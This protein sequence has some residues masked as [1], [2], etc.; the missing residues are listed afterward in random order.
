VC[1]F[2]G[3]GW[4]IAQLFTQRFMYIEPRGNSLIIRW[5]F[6][7][8]NYHI[9][10]KDHNNSICYPLAEA[11]LKRIQSDIRS[12][13]FD[14]TLAKYCTRKAKAAKLESITASELFAKYAD[15]RMEDYELSNSSKVR[16]EGISSKL[17]QLL[18]EKFP[19]SKV[20]ADVAANVIAAWS[21]QASSRTIRAYLFD[22]AAA[23]DWAKKEDLYIL[24]DINPWN[25]SLERL[26]RVKFPPAKKPKPFTIEELKTIAQGF[27]NHPK[28]SYY[29]DAA[30]FISQTA[31][32]FGEMAAL[33]WGNVGEN[34]DTVIFAAS[35]SRGHHRDTTKTGESRT[36]ALTRTVREMLRSRYLSANPNPVELVFPAP[37][38][39]YMNDNRFRGKIWKPVLESCGIDYQK[40]YNLRHTGVSHAAASGA[41]LSALAEQTGHSKRTLVS[42]YLHAIGQECLFV[43]I[44]EP[45]QQT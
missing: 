24:G 28:H 43:D 27:R 21:E 6:E 1:C 26:K 29:T 31:C 4:S 16:F 3:F 34:F 13:N 8:K 33:R 15:R 37:K 41:N 25:N 22:L 10:L 40:P 9:S 39:G 32:R 35:V 19:A 5:K 44:Q 2:G 42:T 12:N 30:I 45:E 38:G 17:C 18:K 7:G 36:V 14:P 23:W 11:R 20:T